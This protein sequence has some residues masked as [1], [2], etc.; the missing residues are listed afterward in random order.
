MATIAVQD[1][2]EIFKKA[3]KTIIK[4]ERVVVCTVVPFDRN[5]G[6]GWIRTS[7]SKEAKHQTILGN[8]LCCCL[9]YSMPG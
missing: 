1:I 5:D 4:R 6:Q 8:R 2:E 7:L 9:G 3:G